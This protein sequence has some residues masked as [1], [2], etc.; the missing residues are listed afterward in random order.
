MGEIDKSREQMFR[1]LESIAVLEINK[2]AK[3]F[4]LE[5][6]KHSKVPETQKKSD[7]ERRK[8]TDS[9]KINSSSSK[10]KKHS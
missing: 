1:I 2:D 9:N 3:K 10:T 4:N 5:K 7:D 8:S 6:M